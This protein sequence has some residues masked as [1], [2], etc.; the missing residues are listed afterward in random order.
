MKN[1]AV[2]KPDIRV[3]KTYDKLYSAFFELL[4]SQP[5]DSITV[6]DLCEKADVH[7]AT[8]YKH[9]LDKQDF[10]SFC[11]SR[12][13]D[14]LNLTN[15]ILLLGEGDESKVIYVNMCKKVINFVHD[16]RRFI[17]D[18]NAS[19]GSEAFSSAL[20]RAFTD[21]FEKRL[22]KVVLNGGILA[23][24]IPMLASYYAGGVVSM[25]KWWA[26]DGEKYTKE[27]ILRFAVTRFNEAEISF[28]HNKCM[29]DHY[30]NN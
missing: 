5:Y 19:P 7:R 9:F 15:D 21:L 12:L 30:N 24:P 23:S 22:T 28:L 13:L 29:K 3:K 2:R 8:F 10:V 25:L 16:N 14:E 1:T 6:L 20:L 18:I 26:I 17:R 4:S 11:C 27:E